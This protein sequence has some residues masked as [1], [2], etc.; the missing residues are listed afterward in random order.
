M[1]LLS[2]PKQNY[3]SNRGFKKKIQFKYDLLSWNLQ[4]QTK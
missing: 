1:E 3:Q 2:I 4:K